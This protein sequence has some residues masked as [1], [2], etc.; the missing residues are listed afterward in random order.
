MQSAG[1]QGCQRNLAPLDF[2]NLDFVD[3]NVDALGIKLI[4]DCLLH[5]PECFPLR[6]ILRKDLVVP[7]SEVVYVF[8]LQFFLHLLSTLSAGGDA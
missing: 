1:R 6:L 5:K 3:W 4:P 8:V 7:A 2:I